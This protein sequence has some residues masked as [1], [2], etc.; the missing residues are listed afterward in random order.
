[1]LRTGGIVKNAGKH[2]AERLKKTYPEPIVCPAGQVLSSDG[3]SCA[4]PC[5]GT[6]QDCIYNAEQEVPNMLVN[7]R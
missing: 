2:P 4:P 1:M 5:D 3:L 6:Y 7:F